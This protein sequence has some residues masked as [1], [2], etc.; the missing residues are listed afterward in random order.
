MTDTMS[1]HIGLAVEGM[2]IAGQPVQLDMDIGLL[3]VVREG[4]IYERRIER[5]GT[6]RVRPGMT[7]SPSTVSFLGFG[8]DTDTEESGDDLEDQTEEYLYTYDSQRLEP[9][10][11]PDVYVAQFDRTTYHRHVRGYWAN[12]L[13]Q[14]ASEE[15]TLALDRMFRSTHGTRFNS[16]PSSTDSESTSIGDEQERPKKNVMLRSLRKTKAVLS[17]VFK[18][19]TLL[20]ALGG[21]RKPKR[22]GRRK[23]NP[24]RITCCIS[25]GEEPTDGEYQTLLCPECRAAARARKISITQRTKRWFSRLKDRVCRSEA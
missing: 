17:S 2:A 18:P 1:E 4:Y 24:D 15:A 19:R 5:N 16:P 12:R 7:R 13:G 22:R 9:R 6:E 25:G 11:E 8:F 21:K 10:V 23:G 3:R 14:S 20:Q